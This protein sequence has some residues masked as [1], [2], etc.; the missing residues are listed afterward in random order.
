MTFLSLLRIWH[1]VPV[2]TTMDLADA[3]Q[4]IETNVTPIAG[5]TRCPSKRLAMPFSL[6]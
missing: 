6:R 2:K 1:V 3:I 5:N 4:L